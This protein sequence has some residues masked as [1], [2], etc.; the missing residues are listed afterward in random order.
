MTFKN[1]SVSTSLISLMFLTMLS[2]GND[3]DIVVRKPKSEPD[4]AKENLVGSWT[5]VSIKDESPLVF[6][7][8]A[9]PDIVGPDDPDAEPDIVG[10]DDVSS[11]INPDQPDEEEGHKI[12]ID[13]FY[14]DFAADD[15]WTLNVQFET[16]LDLD[17]VLSFDDMPPPGEGLST[18]GGYLL[19]GKVEIKGIWSGTY[20]IIEDNVLSLITK[21]KD[22]NIMSVSEGRF[23]KALSKKKIAV[24][25][26]LR[27]KF[28]EHVLTPF[29]KTFITLEGKTLNLKSTGSGRAKMVLEKQ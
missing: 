29:S 9:E 12:D 4:F 2:C 16:T 1:F 13:H 10:P 17:D 15:L 7:N 8:A 20:S 3:E 25:S 5:V 23:E 26:D 19:S 27:K 18:D 21:E 11:F 22:V 6:I 24:L 28:R 14:F